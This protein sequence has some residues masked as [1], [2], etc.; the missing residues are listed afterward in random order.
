M[1]VVAACS[2]NRSNIGLLKKKRFSDK[3][4]RLSNQHRRKWHFLSFAIVFHCI[5]RPTHGVLIAVH[6]QFPV[7]TLL[8]PPRGTELTGHPGG[9]VVTFEYYWRVGP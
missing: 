7:E 4:A 9:L 5:P 6:L 3:F 2:K 8:L 1:V